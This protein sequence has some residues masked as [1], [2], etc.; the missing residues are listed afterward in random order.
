[1]STRGLR[2]LLTVDALVGLVAG[3]ALLLVPDLFASL[4]GLSMAPTGILVARL[5]G[6][7]LAGF[8][9]ATWLA[10]GGA[11]PR[12]PI[13]LGHIVNESLTAIV[14]AL[15]LLSGFGGPLLAALAATA[16]ALAIVFWVTA[17]TG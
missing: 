6:G 8:S 12:G 4:S 10:R 16:A 2:L 7:E 17:L 1:V 14:V 13:V 3:L 11:S 15:G 5:Y 9:L